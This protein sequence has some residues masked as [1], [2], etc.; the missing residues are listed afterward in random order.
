M[1]RSKR[2][3]L[4]LDQTAVLYVP[5][6]PEPKR[7]LR[8]FSQETTQ[9]ETG[10]FVAEAE[11]LARILE[12]KDCPPDI[13]NTIRALMIGACVYTAKA[14]DTHHVDPQMPRDLWPY[15]RAVEGKKLR[16]MFESLLDD[17]QQAA[18]EIYDSFFPKPRKKVR[19]GK[20]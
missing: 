11:V 12:H 17:L 8:Y 14:L 16:D 2:L 18:P 15:A 19:H 4:P 1:P 7:K 3:D 20:R 5:F 10:V 6:T 13:R 9:K